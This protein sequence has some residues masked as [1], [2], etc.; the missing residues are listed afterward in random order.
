VVWSGSSGL[1]YAP[2]AEVLPPGDFQ[3]SVILAAFSDGPVFRTPIMI[4]VRAGIGDRIEVDASGGIIPSSVA[5]P[6]A[7]GAAVRWN[8]LSPRSDVGLS[9]AL[10]GKVSFQYDSSVGNESILST[11]TFADFTGVSVGVPLQLSLGRVSLLASAGFTT[12]LWYPYRQQ[13]VQ[14]FGWFYLR[15]GI[16]F[17]FGPATAGVSASARTAPLIPD[18]A[19]AL[20]TPVPVQVAAEI[21]WLIP[22]TQ[23][24]VSGVVA[25]EF[26]TP[27]S[28][29]LMGGGGLGFL[30]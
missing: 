11:D 1:M 23:I 13:L 6:F 26:D 27:T 17:D 5:V 8:F 12:S 24:L 30:Y 3:A 19:F 29:Y 18:A 14:L 28:Y 21:H 20:G 16:M 15:S 2:V 4:G 9:G 7:L 10:E 22:D 25:G